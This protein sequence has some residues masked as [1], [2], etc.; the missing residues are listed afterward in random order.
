MNELSEIIKIA[1]IHADRIRMALYRLSSILP[2]DEQKVLSFTEQDLLLTDL[3]VNRFGKLQDI[4]G[5]TIID[6]FLDSVEELSDGA[7][8]LDKINQLERMSIINNAS[9]WKDMRKAHNHAAH[10]YP[11]K[12]ALTAKYLNDIVDLAPKLIDILNN[13]KKKDYK[14]QFSF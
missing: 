11:D 14:A 3:L 6:M 8:M 13:I 10:E 1:D 5:K 4:I 7:T 2:F 9:T 12:P